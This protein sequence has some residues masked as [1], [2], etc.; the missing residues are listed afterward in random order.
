[1]R[2]ILA[3]DAAVSVAAGVFDEE[4]APSTKATIAVPIVIVSDRPGLVAGR[5]CAN[6][7][8]FPSVF[9]S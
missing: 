6:I 4:H 9:P 2:V 1:M 7:A 3:S 5:E 8:A